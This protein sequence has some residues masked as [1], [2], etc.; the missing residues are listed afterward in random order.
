MLVNF[1]II[2]INPQVWLWISFLSWLDFW[3]AMNINM[4]YELE[5]RL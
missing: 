3:N 1:E 4:K 2:M 5:V